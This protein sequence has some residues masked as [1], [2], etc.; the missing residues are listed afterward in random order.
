M[1]CSNLKYQQLNITFHTTLENSVSLSL[2]AIMKG[3]PH[4][5]HAAPGVI[6]NNKGKTLGLCGGFFKKNSEKIK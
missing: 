2:R 1:K 3:H 5:A 4:K 6:S